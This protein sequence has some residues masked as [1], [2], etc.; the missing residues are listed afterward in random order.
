MIYTKGKEDE[1]SLMNSYR[2]VIVD[3]EPMAV[4]AIGR[5]IEK[6]CPGYEVAG[7]ASNGYG[8]P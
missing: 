6:N 5:V 8:A 3:D 2:V 4:K 7:T 1:S